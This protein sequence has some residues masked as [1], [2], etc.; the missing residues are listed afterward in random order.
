MLAS[1]DTNDLVFHSLDVMKSLL[2][3]DA[4][5]HYKTLAVLDVKISHGGELLRS[6][7]VEYLQHTGGAI[8]LYFLPIEI[9][10]G[11][12]VFFYESIWDELNG[13]GWFSN[14]PASQHHN[15]ELSHCCG[16][17]SLGGRKMIILAGSDRSS[18]FPPFFV[19]S[20]IGTIEKS[21]PNMDTSRQE[22]RG[23]RQCL[24]LWLKNLS[25][26]MTPDV[27]QTRLHNRWCAQLN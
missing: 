23:A 21:E 4:V 3:G 11:R 1:L 19:T 5:D 24:K 15:F 27:R 8:D 18:F 12:V 6:G 14:S 9:L 17:R 20:E 16:A 22:Y 25:L 7:S 2:T 13:Q 26:Y 10:Y